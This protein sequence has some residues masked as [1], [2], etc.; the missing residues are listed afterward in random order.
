M[1]AIPYTDSEHNGK[2]SSPS[3]GLQNKTSRRQNADRVFLMPERRMLLARHSIL[4]VI[5]ALSLSSCGVDS[6]AGADRISASVARD[7]IAGTQFHPEKS[8]R[9]GLKLIGNFLAWKP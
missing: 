1:T 7:T 9:L 8:Q 5:G 6:R 3:I 2:A 4:S